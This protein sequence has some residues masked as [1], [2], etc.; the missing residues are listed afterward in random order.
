[1]CTFVLI[2]LLNC[3]LLLKL[4]HFDAVGKGIPQAIHLLFQSRVVELINYLEK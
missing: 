3:Y 2:N 1:M 4:L